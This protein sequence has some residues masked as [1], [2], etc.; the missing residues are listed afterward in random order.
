MHKS[1]FPSIGDVIFTASCRA[2]EQQQLGLFITFEASRLCDKAKAFYFLSVN[3][4]PPILRGLVAGQTCVVRYRLQGA[5]S[6]YGFGHTVLKD[7]R[8]P[9]PWPV[10]RKVLG[11]TPFIALVPPG[12]SYCA[13]GGG[14]FYLGLLAK[15][16]K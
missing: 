11:D 12:L 2:S 15:M 7:E 4:T 14:G 3:K 10:P 9:V 16:A 1:L 6:Y 8:E 5:C 13:A